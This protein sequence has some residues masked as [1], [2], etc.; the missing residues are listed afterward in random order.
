MK[1][2]FLGDHPFTSWVGYGL[3]ALTTADAMLKTGDKN[4]VEIGIAVL[5]AVLGRVSAD[6]LNT[7]KQ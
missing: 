2:T 4:Y 5:L 1:K 3:A 7:P 6:S